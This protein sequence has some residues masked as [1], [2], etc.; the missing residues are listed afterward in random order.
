M[1]AGER[2]APENVE[3]KAEENL[4]SMAA[5]CRKKDNSEI[6]ITYFFLIL[7]IICMAVNVSVGGMWLEG[8]AV[9]SNLLPTAFVVVAGGFV[10]TFWDADRHIVF[11]LG[12]P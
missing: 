1:F 6:Y 5:E 9:F 10:L 7:L 4:K 8:S 12:L 2:T 11:W 3:K